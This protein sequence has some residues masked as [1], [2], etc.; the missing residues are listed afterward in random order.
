[1]QH[2]VAMAGAAEVASKRREMN[3]S[4]FLAAAIA[5][6][7]QSSGTPALATSPP[8]LTEE[9][10]VR[11][12]GSFARNAPDSCYS[13][14]ACGA[15]IALSGD[16]RYVAFGTQFSDLVPGDSNEQMDVF[17][18]DRVLGVTKLVSK[19]YSGGPASGPS[20][21]PSISDDGRF[22]A[23]L[24]QATDLVEGLPTEGGSRIYVTD[25]Q[26]GVT[27]HGSV[28]PDGQL[29]DSR[30]VNQPHLSDDGR[31]LMFQ[32]NGF[33]DDTT[34]DERL[35]YGGL[36][37]GLHYRRDLHSGVTEMIE[38]PD[39]GGRSISADVIGTEEAISGDG[40]V[41]AFASQRH[42]LVA[43][44]R[45]G[46]PDVFVRDL[47]S[48]RT[49]LIS[50]G[51]D[52][53]WGNGISSVPVINADGR[54]VAFQSTSSNL[55]PN[56]T[57]GARLP[58]QGALGSGADVFLRDRAAKTT[59]RI[60]LTDAGLEPG[61]AYVEGISDDGRLI[62]FQTG[63]GEYTPGAP[64]MNR[65]Y[66]HDRLRGTTELVTQQPDGSPGSSSS[67]IGVAVSG[68][69]RY[70][71]YPAPNEG[72]EFGDGVFVRD[73]GPR[74]GFGRLDVVTDGP[75]RR[76]E[77][78]ARIDGG[79]LAS[80]GSEDEGPI[81]GAEVIWRPEAQDL[82]VR[83]DIPHRLAL[84]PDIA[85]G[86][87]VAPPRR[88]GGPER[89]VVT[90]IE[91]DGSRWE[92]ATDPGTSGGD[93]G[94]MRRRCAPS[95]GAW[96]ETPGGFGTAGDEFRVPIPLD[97]LASDTV[98]VT[99]DA[100]LAGTGAL[101]ERVSLGGFQIPDAFVAVTSSEIAPATGNP[102]GRTFSLVIPEGDAF[103][104]LCGLG[105]VTLPV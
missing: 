75:V 35:P 60:S 83:V 3:R 105:C 29:P 2:A 7:L 1:M 70:V 66:V 9:M 89:Y 97:D 98:S 12:D 77:G 85:G 38:V 36:H 16:G 24:S 42:D 103:V 44:D 21:W 28:G 88:L 53:A 74:F 15:S 84:S 81:R 30:G 64:N 56:D 95:C 55:V 51:T 86:F 102:I 101:A 32:S 58:G 72:S 25:M 68:N 31:Y 92:I 99:I 94:F 54:F 23:F 46:V 40:Q 62:V 65:I 87:A 39:S 19:S 37:S 6:F 57:N 100:D 17:V 76:A 10:T 49:E 104:H 8:G 11:P 33:A 52:G 22:I 67:F 93:A 14:I 41:I 4:L 48:Q 69:G 27:V 5:L 82:L 63:L 91:S 79:T 78:W 61:L 47:R 20:A 43:G 80:V 59:V 90:I 13:T 26:T 34:N 73:M 45:N 18:R 50:V 96:T 71:G